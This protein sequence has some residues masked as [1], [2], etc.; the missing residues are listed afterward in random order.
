MVQSIPW[1][2]KTTIYQV[3]PR[4]FVDSNGDGIGDLRGIISRLDY[5]KDLGFETIWFSP[6]FASPQQDWGYD[7]SGY[8]KI[9]PEYGTLVD[10]ERLIEEIHQRGMKVIFDLVL[11]H[12]S[13]KHPWFI[14]SSANTWSARNA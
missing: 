8:R 13:D 4:S 12:S 9:A 6:F 2:Q 5:I 11:N 3:Y 14:E 7:I 1:W 10:A